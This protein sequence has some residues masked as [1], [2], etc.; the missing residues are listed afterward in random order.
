MSQTIQVKRGLAANLPAVL[1]VGELAYTTDTQKLYVGTGTGRVEINRDEFTL[2][3]VGTP[4]EYIKVT[5]D[6]KGRVTAGST[7]IPSTSVTGL[8]TSATKNTGT[9]SGDV[10]ILGTGG[11]L[12][13]SVIPAVAITDTFVVATEAAMLALTA[14]VGDVA[15]RTD[16]SKSFILQTEPATSLANWQELISPTD[17]VTSVAGKTGAVTLNKSDVGLGNVLNVAQIPATEKGAN[18]GVATLNSSGKLTAAQKPD[19]TKSD[20]GLGNVDNTSDADKPISTA[21]AAALAEKAPLASPTFTGT[22]KATT[23]AADTNTTQ[24][25]TTAFVI[26]QASSSAPLGLAEAGVVGTSKKYARADHQHPMPTVID[27]GSF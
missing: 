2:P 6:S 21:T 24:I 27:G 1:Q 10:P 17:K 13:A 5:V 23:A 11:K 3:D 18:S 9:A 20:V 7:T 22:P 19:Y 25:A 16:L 15:I 26:G 8:G 12:D 4:G 14:Q